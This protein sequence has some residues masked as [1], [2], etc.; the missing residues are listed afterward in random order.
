MKYLPVLLLCW[1]SLSASAQAIPDSVTHSPEKFADHLRQH[2]STAASQVRSLYSWITSNIKYDTDSALYI[3]WSADY[4]GKISATLR[5]RKGVCENFASLFADISRRLGIRSYVVHGYPAYADKNKDNSHGWVAVELDNQWFLCDPTWDAGAASEKYYMSSPSDFIQTHIPFDPIWQLL[6][7]PKNYHYAGPTFNYRDSIDSYLQLD[8]LQQYQ[9]TE[10]RIKNSALQN[11]MTKN[12][13][14]FNRM[15]IA[16]ISGEEDRIHYDAAVEAVNEANRVL[17]SFIKFRNEQ[18]TPAKTEEQLSLM[19][20]PIGNLLKKAES[21]LIQLG[22]NTENFQ[23]DPATLRQ[24]IMSLQ[25]KTD[26][27]ELFLQ[28]YLTTPAGERIKLF[29]K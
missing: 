17:N 10:R 15:N 25:S 1:F 16:V 20:S 27:Q 5:R 23:Y 22:K 19:L 7:R 2:H 21:H 13:Q 12:W 24:R 3:N 8:S 18:F 29:Y 14:Q 9:A 4:A 26:Q 28:R 6:E 11:T